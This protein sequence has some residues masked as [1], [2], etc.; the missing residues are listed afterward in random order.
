MLSRWAQRGILERRQDV[1]ALL[2]VLGY[3]KGLTRRKRAAE[4]CTNAVKNLLQTK[5]AERANKFKFDTCLQTL[6]IT[7]FQK[8]R[9]WVGVPLPPDARRGGEGWA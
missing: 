5:P 6:E 1:L 4:K 8:G 2:I 7:F 3:G 9:T